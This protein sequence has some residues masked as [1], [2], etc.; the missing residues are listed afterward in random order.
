MNDAKKAG[1]GIADKIL[2]GLLALRAV[3]Q[4]LVGVSFVATDVVSASMWF[5][6]AAVYAGGFWALRKGSKWGF[7]TVMGISVF[8]GILSFSAFSSNPASYASSIV[9]DM[10][11]LLLSINL[12]RHNPPK[13]RISNFGWISFSIVLAVISGITLMSLSYIDSMTGLP[14]YIGPEALDAGSYAYSDFTTDSYRSASVELNSTY[15]NKLD[16]YLVDPKGMED[17]KAGDAFEFYTDGSRFNVT[18][19]TYQVALPAGQ[20]SFI[21]YNPSETESAEFYLTVV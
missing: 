20:W 14:M 9:T 19:A 8:D 21:V 11:I 3:G 16:I 7:F 4:L 17:I 13:K 5:I 15:G 1:M 12:Y 2:F 10:I 6:L 18:H